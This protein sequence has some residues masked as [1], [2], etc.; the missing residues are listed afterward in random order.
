MRYSRKPV[1]NCYSCLLN[2]GDHCWIY[3]YPRGQWCHKRKCRAFEN[4]EIYSKF[5][6]WRKLPEIK[7]RKDIRRVFFRTTRKRERHYDHMVGDALK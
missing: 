5:R 6:E 7:T 2:L 4:E 3:K 1:H